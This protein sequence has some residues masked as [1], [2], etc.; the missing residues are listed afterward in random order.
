MRRLIL[1]IVGVWSGLALMAEPFYVRINGTRDVPATNTGVKDYQERTQYAAMNVSLAKND[2]LTCYDAGSGAAWNIA[3]ID[4]YGAYANFS[5]G[6]SALTCNVAGTYDIYIKMK[7][8]DDMWFIQS[9]DGTSPEPYSPKDYEVAVPAQCEDI[10]LQA[11]YWDSPWD[12]EYGNT[13]WATLTGQAAEIGS[14]FSLVWLPPSSAP[15]SD[16][17]GYIASCY[18]NQNS[19][20]GSE[21]ELRTLLATLHAHDVKVL[22]DIVINHCGNKGSWCDFNELNFGQ[23]GTFR[24][25]ASWITSD[26]EGGC[27]PSGNA[28]DGQ[29]EANYEAARD[30]DHTDENVQNMCKAYTKWMK[31]VMLYDGFR[32][33]Y[34][35]GFHTKH[36]NAY[37]A[38]AKPY[39]SV[40]EYWYGDAATL[41]SRIDNAVKNSLAFDFALKYNTFRDGIFK[42]SYTKCI[43]GGLRGKGYEKY[44]VT[45]IDNHDTFNRGNGNEPNGKGDGSSINDKSLMMRCNAYLLSMPGVPCVFYPHWIK[46]KAE[47]KKMIEARRAAGIHSQS[48]VDE[49]A[50]TGWYR[51]TVH[52]KKGAIKLMLGTAAEDEAPAGYTLVLKGTDYALYYILGED[53]MQA[54]QTVPALDRTQPVYNIMGQRVDASFRGLVIQ[55]GNKY[56]NQ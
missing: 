2:R 40:M 1:C 26:D 10:M 48:L 41:K 35:G 56:Y 42:K 5:T 18:S 15:K 17:L 33:D 44:A 50:D 16:G 55:N 36:I 4:P 12:K 45:F 21:S 22:A 9:S 37:N 30:W 46:Y 39:F 14:Y 52:G 27:N 3:V 24:P 32:Y 20:L 54:L 43:N 8:N 23:Y 11:F 51:A 13:R 28:D 7:M 6:S 31:K 19:S 53:T 29:H 38:A 47:I 25:D 34:C 49:S